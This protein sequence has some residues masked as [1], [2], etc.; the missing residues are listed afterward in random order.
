MTYKRLLSQLVKYNEL[1]IKIALRLDYLCIF[2]KKILL[3]KNS[4]TKTS[5]SL[6][7]TSKKFSWS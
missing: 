5:F 1:T 2:K 3:A 6:K 4:K 7:T